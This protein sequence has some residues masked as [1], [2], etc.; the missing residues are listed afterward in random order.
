QGLTAFD[1]DEENDNLL[2]GSKIGYIRYDLKKR[3]QVGV[4]YD[5]IPSPEI[6][7]VKVL[8]EKIWFGTTKGAFAVNRDGAIDYYASE[9]W[10]PSD[11]VLQISSGK[12]S[13]VLV[14]TSDGLSEI[15]FK[16][17]TLHDKAMFYEQQVRS[18][19]IRNGF[20]AAL[21]GMEKG[22]V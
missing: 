9:R 4:L 20:N 8:G 7:A 6:T 2:I 22:N 14:L 3:Q 17:M 12:D 21:T 13:A 16:S 1:L 5:K 15:C 11:H 19:H 10:L 18:R